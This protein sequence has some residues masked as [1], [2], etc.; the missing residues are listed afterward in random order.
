MGQRRRRAV[1]SC[2]ANRS[3]ILQTK[4]TD[5]KASSLAGP[6]GQ[7]HS[8]PASTAQSGNLNRKSCNTFQKRLISKNTQGQ[9][10]FWAKHACCGPFSLKDFLLQ[11]ASASY[12][13]WGPTAFGQDWGAASTTP[14]L[15]YRSHSLQLSREAASSRGL[16]RSWV[17]TF[18]LLF[19]DKKTTWGGCFLSGPQV[20]AAKVH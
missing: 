10:S 8:A 14:I 12:K 11:Q 9:E 16:N 19:K 15:P 13:L 20:S 4:P 17:Q 3:A 7:P 6:P 5:P 1:H 18:G 2:P